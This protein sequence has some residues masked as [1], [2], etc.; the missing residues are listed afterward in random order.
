MVQLGAI[1]HDLHSEIS[2][3]NYVVSSRLSLYL[4]LDSR[5]KRSFKLPAFRIGERTTL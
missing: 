2:Q 1:I 5:Q 3:I 4:F